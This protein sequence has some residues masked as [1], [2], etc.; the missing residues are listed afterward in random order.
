M[1]VLGPTQ[2]PAPVVAAILRAEL[3]GVQLADHVGP[4]QAGLV[5]VLQELRVR[6][7]RAGQDT[8]AQAAGVPRSRQELGEA[9]LEDLRYLCQSLW[10]DTFAALEHFVALSIQLQR[11]RE[12]Q[13]LLSVDPPPL[14]SRRAHLIRAGARRDM[15]AGVLHEA[16]V[17]V[18]RRVRA[19]Y[20]A[21]DLHLWAE[22]RKH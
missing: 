5:G 9:Y 16:T 3:E 10:S 8:R 20:V 22:R 11:R 17:S 13:V 21:P 15:R 4:R 2:E 19:E 7:R 18:A 1:R 12:L 14:R 6:Q